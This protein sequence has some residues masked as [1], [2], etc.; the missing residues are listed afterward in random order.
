MPH[1]LTELVRVGRVLEEAHRLLEGERKRLE[2][3][4]GRRR[5]YEVTAGSPT[6]TLRGATDLAESMAAGLKQVSLTIGYSVL[7]MDDRA[8]RALRVARMQ[9]VSF[10]SGADRMARPLGE[11]TVRAMELIRDLGFFDEETSIAIDVALA[12]PQATYPPADWD[13]YAREQGAQSGR[14]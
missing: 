2:Q 3:Q 13:A 10:P 12:A 8:D 9:P 14:D 5:P 7:G 1:D 11:D 4:H 6:Q